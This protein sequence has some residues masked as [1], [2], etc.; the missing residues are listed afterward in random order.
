MSS[1]VAFHAGQLARNLLA[2]A[3]LAFFLPVRG[4]SF[5]ASP[6]QFALLALFNLAVWIAVAGERSG[7]QGE[8]QPSAISVYLG[9]VALVLATAFLVA[10]AYR[11]PGRLL[12]IAVALSASDALFDLAALALVAAGA[13]ERHASALYV[14]FVAWAWLASLRAAVVCCGW[15]RPAVYLAG[16][17]VTLMTGVALLVIPDADVWLLP[18]DEEEEQM[19]A[20]FPLKLPGQES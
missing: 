7:F 8:F 3:R 15:R 9:N 2:G 11:T 19:E 16:L 12:L 4:E 18:D 10:H 14:A 6:E 13:A 20:Q 1:A 17:A 5:R